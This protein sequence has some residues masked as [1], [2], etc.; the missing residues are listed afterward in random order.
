[1]VEIVTGIVIVEEYLG[2]GEDSIQPSGTWTE[3]RTQQIH[4]YKGFGSF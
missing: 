1:M 4:L 3:N 2:K